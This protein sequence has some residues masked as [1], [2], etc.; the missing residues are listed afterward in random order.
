MVKVAKS[1]REIFFAHI[2]TRPRLNVATN[3]I[4][5]DE[6]LCLVWILFFM[7][8]MVRFTF[9]FRQYL[10]ELCI[11][12]TVS[13]SC[14]R[15]RYCERAWTAS[16]HEI[17]WFQRQPPLVFRILGLMSLPKSVAIRE[18]RGLAEPK[19]WQVA[20]A[21]LDVNG[22][23]QWTLLGPLYLF[24]IHRPKFFHGL[25]AS[26]RLSQKIRYSV[27][28]YLFFSWKNLLN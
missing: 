10:R 26:V 24:E 15:I 19:I 18:R 3:L 23:K 12:S 11:K 1:F 17:S 25:L 6:F 28:A 20:I 4:C 21:Q 5:S 27:W 14:Q 16:V 9:F 7:F 2:Q 22:R 8:S 13:T